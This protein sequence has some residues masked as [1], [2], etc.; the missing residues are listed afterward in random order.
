[1][2]SRL[3]RC[4]CAP[5]YDQQSIAHHIE[6]VERRLRIM[7]RVSQVFSDHHG[8]MLDTIKEDYQDITE[9]NDVFYE[10]VDRQLDELKILR[11]RLEE[12]HY[13]I[14]IEGLLNSEDFGSKG[15]AA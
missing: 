12:V 2:S 1:M 10:Y 9:W 8:G 11:N 13:W 6:N 4:D 5:D 14:S 7:C 15:G 3:R